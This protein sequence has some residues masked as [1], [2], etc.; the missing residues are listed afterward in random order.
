MDAITTIAQDWYVATLLLGVCML[1]LGGHLLV[2]GSVAIAT[3]LG[4]SKLVIGLT[5]V[6]FSTSSP[7]LALNVIASLNGHGDLCLGNIFGSN[8]A[9]IGLVLG[10]GALIC[11]LPV[12]S[13]LIKVEF[14]LLV[15]ATGIVGGATLFFELNLYWAIFFLGLFSLLMW[16]WFHIGNEDESPLGA[17]SEEIAPVGHT[18]T[19]RAWIL[20]IAGLVLLG[21]GGKATEI[22]AVTGA[23]ALGMSEIVVGGTVIAIATSLPEVVTTI[24]AAKKGHP[25]LAVGNVVGSNIFNILFV[26]PITILVQPIQA[27]SGAWIYVAVMFGITLIAWFL[28]MDKRIK[29]KE[30]IIL[31]GLYVLFLTWVSLF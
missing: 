28:A 10:I 14:P 25:D 3:K 15:A 4:I 19:V 5:I 21:F 22:G 17:K 8:I 6:A 11:K 13:R 9:N 29:S 24:I 18:S 1:I 30:G 2:E 16:Q 7:E 12:T 26:L 20:L 23:L 31:I 27:S